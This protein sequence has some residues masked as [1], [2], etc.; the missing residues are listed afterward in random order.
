[1]SNSLL[2]CVRNMPS[3]GGFGRYLRSRNEREHAEESILALASRSTRL[4]DVICERENAHMAMKY[5]AQIVQLQ[6]V[7]SIGQAIRGEGVMI[8]A[9]NPLLYLNACSVLPVNLLEGTVRSIEEPTLGDT[10]DLIDSA[11]FL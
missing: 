9:H 2:L 4:G 8:G 1:M 6:T 5:V 10:I 3:W 7:A 11:E